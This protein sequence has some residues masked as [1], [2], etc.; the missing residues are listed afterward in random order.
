MVEFRPTPQ[1]SFVFYL[2]Q[3]WHQVGIIADMLL[4]CCRIYCGPVLIKAQI[5]GWWTEILR[6]ETHKDSRWWMYIPNWKLRK[7][8]YFIKRMSPIHA[9]S[10]S[11]Q[12]KREKVKKKKKKIIVC[13]AQ[14]TKKGI[15]G[16]HFSYLI[17]KLDRNYKFKKK[18]K[19]WATLLAARI[20]L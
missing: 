15:Q 11:T 16:R 12:N 13:R 5:V 7:E 10:Y 20:N 2:K 6:R 14:S 3:L 1:N 9:Y 18:K 8:R 17:S 4:K 19:G